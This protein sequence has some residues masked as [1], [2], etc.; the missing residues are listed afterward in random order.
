MR[1]A[2]RTTIEKNLLDALKKNAVDRGV[3]ANDILEELLTH[4]FKSEAQNAEEIQGLPMEAQIKFFTKNI[5]ELL[6]D[7]LFSYR[8]DYR[9]A[10]RNIIEDVIR[11]VLINHFDD[12]VKE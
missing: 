8:I 10:P 5:M 3:D 11:S 12:E 2:F 7:Y 6:D 9:G 1:T 4:Y